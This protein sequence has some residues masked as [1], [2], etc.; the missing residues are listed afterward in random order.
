MVGILGTRL[1]QPAG[2]FPPEISKVNHDSAAWH[3]IIVICS[4]FTWMV[5]L[6]ILCLALTTAA[7]LVRTPSKSSPGLNNQVLN[8]IWMRHMYI[9]PWWSGEQWDRPLEPKD[10][11]NVRSEPQQPLAPDCQSSSIHTALLGWS[12]SLIT[13]L[14]VSCT[15]S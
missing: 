7:A 9:S 1:P 3:E 12:F 4:I 15:S 13:L 14:S 10:S 6:L 5:I 11:T 8:K 2:E